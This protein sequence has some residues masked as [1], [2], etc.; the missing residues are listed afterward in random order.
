MKLKFVPPFLFFFIQFCKSELIEKIESFYEIRK[1]VKVDGKINELFLIDNMR[2]D[3]QI[4]CLA[5]CNS[6]HNCIS[7]SYLVNSTKNCFLYNS[8][9]YPSSNSTI[10]MDFYNKLCKS[11]ELC[12]SC[13]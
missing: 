7:C 11:I 12:A 3:S 9:I 1:D 8:F 13:S 10:K 5:K 6:H 4:F 2:V